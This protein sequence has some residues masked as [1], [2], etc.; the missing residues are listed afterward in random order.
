MQVT[1]LLLPLVTAVSPH[2][3]DSLPEKEPSFRFLVGSYAPAQQSGV[4]LMEMNVADGSLKKLTEI[5][6]MENP[7]FL[8]ISSDRQWVYAV[9]EVRDAGKVYSLRLHIEEPRLELVG[10][11]IA[12]GSYPCHITLDS[13]E[14]FVFVGNYGGGSLSVM[15]LK[16]D[17]SLT[18]PVQ[19]I[20]HTGSSI[21][22]N[23]EGPHVHG[24]FFGPGH[25]QLFVPD[26]G[27]DKIVIYQFDGT[28]SFQPLS[29]AS[30]AAM[31]IKPGGG[32][33]HL[34]FSPN[35]SYMY[36]LHENTGAITVFKYEDQKLTPIQLLNS[37]PSSYKGK[38]IGSADI[39]ISKDGKF[40]YASHRGD[41]NQLVICK[42]DAPT[43]KLQVVGHKSTNGRI[44]R[45][46][47]LDPTN[48]YILVANQESDEI[49]VLR[50]NEKTGLL[51]DTPYKIEVSKPVCIQFLP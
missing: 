47:A 34:A 20:Q 40:L 30:P 9:G 5:G 32:P 48:Q 22:P 17:R 16:A 23:Q 4:Y 28:N 2:V 14:Q 21:E 38:N 25:K 29:P 27:I 8:T 11:Q 50:R 3:P 49:V 39:H 26:L 10:Q 1:A 24:V 6:G 42:I 19:T 15:P 33:R 36:I 12:G 13:A 51:S 37:I 7:S 44:P 31:G 43:G 46:F 41:L 18:A 45:N 35:G